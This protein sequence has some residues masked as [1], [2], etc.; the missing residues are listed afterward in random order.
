MRKGMIKQVKIIKKPISIITE[1]SE[2]T[3]DDLFSLQADYM[4]I[5]LNHVL[6]RVRALSQVESPKGTIKNQLK[7]VE[8]LGNDLSEITGQELDLLKFYK[9][10][11]I[12]IVDKNM[13]AIPLISV[14]YQVTGGEQISIVNIKKAQSNSQINFP[15]F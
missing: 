9:N 13:T 7:Y 4:L 2:S 14:S 11:I 8:L 12:D 15:V 10:K 5:Q 6:L 3:I 1:F